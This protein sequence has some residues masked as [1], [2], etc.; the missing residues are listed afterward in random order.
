MVAF[1]NEVNT[2]KKKKYIYTN[3]SIGEQAFMITGVYIIF[4]LLLKNIICLLITKTYL[5][6]YIENLTS[7]KMKV[8]R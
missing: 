3:R 4:L 2:K 6:K 8:L 5:F 1:V 7:K